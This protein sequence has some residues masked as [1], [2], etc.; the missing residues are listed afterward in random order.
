MEASDLSELLG[1]KCVKNVWWPF[2][3]IIKYR[4]N[5]FVM[6]ESNI[7]GWKIILEDGKMNP[8]PLLYYAIYN[9]SPPLL[10]GRKH[11]FTIEFRLSTKK[12]FCQ[13]KSF[14]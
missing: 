10:R 14:F 3:S 12:E 5:Y 4:D 9:L 2:I 7:A 8:P 13:K 6:W 1:P 11:F